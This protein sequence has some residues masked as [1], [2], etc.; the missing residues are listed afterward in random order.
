MFNLS[1]IVRWMFVVHHDLL[2]M[3]FESLTLST[4]KWSTIFF[5]LNVTFLKRLMPTDG[6]RRSDECKEGVLCDT[7]M[8]FF[9]V[10]T[11]NT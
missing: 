3:P 5:E 1:E 7:S 9:D 10:Y 2:P 8:S 11:R 6:K 4:I